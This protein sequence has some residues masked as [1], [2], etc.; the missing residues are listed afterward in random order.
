MQ[1]SIG[2]VENK[3]ILAIENAFLDCIPLLLS[4]ESGPERHKST[5][6]MDPN[7]DDP[8]LIIEYDCQSMI[9]TKSVVNIIDQSEFE[10]SF[11]LGH[12]IVVDVLDW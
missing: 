10:M 7:R 2:L 3:S 12:Q 5:F 6:L 11:A 9:A 8:I 4:T 1:R